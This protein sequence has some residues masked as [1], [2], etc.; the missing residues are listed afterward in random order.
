MILGCD[1]QVEDETDGVPLI[2]TEETTYTL[3]PEGNG[4]ATEIAYTFENRTG[5][6]VYL[7]NCNGQF[8]LSLER[9]ENGTWAPMWSPVLQECLSPPIVI[10]K[11]GVFPI[12]T[13]CMGWI[14][15]Q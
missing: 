14:S 11:G 6:D 10:E 3:V 1:S 9:L 13:F 7:V 4:L 5:G 8:G 12:S 2:Q 15:R